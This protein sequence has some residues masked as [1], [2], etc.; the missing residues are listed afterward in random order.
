MKVLGITGGIGSGKSTVCKIFETFGI[1]V[2]SADDRAKY[3]MAHDQSLISS[4]KNTFGDEAYLQGKLNRT[5]LAQ[6]IFSNAAETSKMNAIVHPAVG[7]DF[8]SWMSMQNAAYV[9]KEAALMIES[10]SYKSLD[11]LIN[12]FAPIETRIERIKIRDPQRSE[13]EIKGIIDK[14][15]SEEERSR[16]SDAIIYNDEKQLLI[17]QVLA[18]HQQFN[19]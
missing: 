17:P 1:P 6:K 3:L 16:L 11:F 8:K 15:V 19:H 12:V 2:Y 9:I 10:G 14:Q 13:S 7:E 18:I 4:I 5:F